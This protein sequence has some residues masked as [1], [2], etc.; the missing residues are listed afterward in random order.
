MKIDKVVNF[1]FPSPP[2]I[3]QLRWVTRPHLPTTEYSNKNK[4][5]QIFLKGMLAFVYY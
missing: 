1:P 4:N 2:D 3:V 5:E